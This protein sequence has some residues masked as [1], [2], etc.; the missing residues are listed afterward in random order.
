MLRRAKRSKID[1][2]APEEEENKFVLRLY[3]YI[4]LPIGA[5]LLNRYM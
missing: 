2:V 1:V 5:V 4:F 3:N